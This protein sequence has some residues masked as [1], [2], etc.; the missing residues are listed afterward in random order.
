MQAAYFREFMLTDFRTGAAILL[1]TSINA[2]AYNVV[3]YKMIAVRGNIVP[4]LNPN[5][6]LH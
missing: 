6:T 1:L 5:E 2:L 4:P 3:H